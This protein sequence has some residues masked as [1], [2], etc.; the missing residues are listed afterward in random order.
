MT[1][2]R[3][4]PAPNRIAYRRIR[5]VVPAILA[6]PPVSKLP[7]TLPRIPML[8]KIGKRRLACRASQTSPAIVH[9]RVPRITPIPKVVS[10]RTG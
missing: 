1:R 2:V 6:M 10:Q 9:N 5:S 4:N 7:R 8:V 3:R